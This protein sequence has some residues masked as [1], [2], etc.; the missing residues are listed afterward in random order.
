MERKAVVERP[1][2]ETRVRAEVALD[3][4]GVTEIRTGLGF[5]DHMLEQLGRHGLFDLRVHAEG[6]L[7][8][9]GHHTVEDVGIVLG[10]AFRQALGER[11][12]ITRFGH[13][14]VPLDEALSRVV[15]DLSNRPCLVWDVTFAT[16][17]LGVVDTELF[18]EWFVAFANNA[19]M[20][21]HV[22]S[23][24]GQNDHHIIESCFKALARALRTACALDPNLGGQVPSTKGTLNT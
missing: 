16:P 7:H 1:T 15:V 5:L 19:G 10:Q 9:D 23:L 24:Y 22:T 17:R 4:N 8:V 18:R 11:K 2:R 20:T 21:L 6:D 3:G 14:Y 12:G 13:A